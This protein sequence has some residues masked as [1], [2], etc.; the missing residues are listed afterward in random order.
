STRTSLHATMT[1]LRD[2]RERLHHL[3]TG[4]EE[5]EANLRAVFDWSYDTLDDAAKGIFRLLGLAP[6][7]NL[8]TEAIAALVGLDTARIADPL[9]RLIDRHL[10]SEQQ[11]GFYELHDLTRV[12]ARNLTEEFDSADER[13]RA[14]ARP[15]R[16][17]GH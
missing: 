17:P 7:A 2:D 6:A 9:D 8:S 10:L 4:S 12:Y 3:R 13:E 16:W 11:P 5:P 1:R 14:R 15:T